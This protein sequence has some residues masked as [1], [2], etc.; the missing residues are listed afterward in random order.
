MAISPFA[1]KPAEPSMLVNVPKLIT[2]YY[3]ETPDPSAP[4]HRVAFGTSG[5]R[6]SAFEKSF[7][8]WHILAITQA[9][10]L[11]RAQNKIDGPLFLG[12]G[13]PCPLGSGPCR[14]TGSTGGK[15]G[16]RHGRPRGRIYAD[17][18]AV[19][20]D[21]HLQPGA[22]NRSCRR[23]RHHTV[24]QS[25]P[26][27]RVQIQPPHRWAGGRRGHGLDRSQSKRIS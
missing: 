6:G 25:A 23:H 15:R 3:A 5:H 1:G 16:G 2:A 12:H 11:Y 9:I 20:R 7:N 17:P 10:C 22:Q 21:S 8:E 18:R 19:P 13:H 27:R 14:R 4:E 24:P 26:G